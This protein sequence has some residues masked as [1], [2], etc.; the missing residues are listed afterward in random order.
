MQQPRLLFVESVDANSVP[1]DTPLEHLHGSAR[2]AAE[3]GFAALSV[4]RSDEG[5][6][7]TPAGF[8]D[9]AFDVHVTAR[10][11]AAA[12]TIESSMWGMPSG[13]DY[14]S[15][16]WI[17]AKLEDPENFLRIED[18]RW[19]M[20]YSSDA[21]DMWGTGA[22]PRA[23]FGR[24]IDLRFSP[25]GQQLIW[26][27][28]VR[29]NYQDVCLVWRQQTGTA[30]QQLVAKIPSATAFFADMSVSLDGR[31][32]LFDAETRLIDLETGHHA[33]LG[34]GIC[35]A[36]W[37]PAAGPSSILAVPRSG[38]N[39]P[40]DIFTLDLS[41]WSKEV[42]GTAPRPI[43][44]IQAAPDGT[45]VAR[46]NNEQEAIAGGWFDH[47]VV[48]DDFFRTL[49]SVVP[50]DEPS[51][52]RRRATRPRWT[53][54]WPEDLLGRPVR[55]DDNFE[56]FLR[57]EAPDRT[58]DGDLTKEVIEAIVARIRH[59]LARI[60]EEP[61]MIVVITNELRALTEWAATAEPDLAAGVRSQVL[62]TL[63]Q[64]LATMGAAS[65]STAAQQVAGIEALVAGRRSPEP[66]LRF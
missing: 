10:L 65:D 62:P 58:V 45:I 40:T 63:R 16:H 59:R 27:E 17:G 4:V 52:W 43:H 18:F 6:L 54:P 48:S 66:T 29:H 38:F 24:V 7:L 12:R 39:E 30:V 35:A 37:Y 50:V 21:G 5:H 31:W 25:D 22:R 56:G 51:G 8:T 26:L 28:S 53:A 41:T 44:G 55:L 46:M 1:G 60:E 61:S 47:L 14:V 11:A 34:S 20:L 33:G 36:C 42:V 32:L 15:V 9:E 19:P 23:A 64:A 2:I 13:A 3:R 57:D 49:E